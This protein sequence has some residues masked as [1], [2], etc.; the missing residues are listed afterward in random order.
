MKKQK[1]EQTREINY[2]DKTLN[3][4]KTFHDIKE[5]FVEKW[6]TEIVVIIIGTIIIGLSLI[7]V[8]SIIQTSINTNQLTKVNGNTI[9]KL[10]ISS[11]NLLP[12]EINESLW[13]EFPDE[14]FNKRIDGEIYNIV[15]IESNEKL[16]I[17]IL[18]KDFSELTTNS[19]DTTNSEIPITIII[20]DGE[21]LIRN[22]IRNL[23]F[24]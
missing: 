22:L 11:D 9:V 24:L 16:S 19:I 10:T 21:R 13:V 12:I 3:S 6:M 7:K 2:S 14:S 18:L 8:P 1:T 23:S 4:R 20:P 17:E 5:S 15:D